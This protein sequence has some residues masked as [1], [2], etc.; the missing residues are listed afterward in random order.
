[1]TDEVGLYSKAYYLRDLRRFEGWREHDV[2]IRSDLDDL[3]T[4]PRPLQDGDVVFLH[5]D[6]RVTDG[7]FGEMKVIFDQVDDRWRKF[8]SEE[9]DFAVPDDVRAAAELAAKD[10]E[11]IEGGSR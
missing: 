2:L 3:E 5:D 4:P 10:L 8:C 9:L 11:N 7:V 1:M 6:Y